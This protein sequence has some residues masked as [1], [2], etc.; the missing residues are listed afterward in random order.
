MGRRGFPICIK[1]YIDAGRVSPAF[2]CDPAKLND[3]LQIDSMHFYQ[4][5]GKVAALAAFTGNKNSMI[6]LTTSIEFEEKSRVIITVEIKDTSDGLNEELA[7][8]FN[9]YMNKEIRDFTIDGYPDDELRLI[10]YLSNEGNA[11]VSMRSEYAR[12]NYYK[13]FMSRGTTVT[14]EIN[15]HTAGAA[16]CCVVHTEEH[17]PQ[18]REHFRSIGIKMNYVPLYKAA[19]SMRVIGENDFVVVEFGEEP[20]PSLMLC[21]DLYNTYSNICIIAAMVNTHGNNEML[22]ES[23]LEHVK[24][25]IP[26]PYNVDAIIQALRLV[27]NNQLIMQKILS[28]FI[29]D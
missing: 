23:L 19:H 7:M 3:Y 15:T 2:H 10:K 18:L 17:D 14:D 25:I 11:Y 1:K 5:V 4:L 21:R 16:S 9:Q 22:I 6:Y 24:C 26:K 28:G 27:K 13:I 29:P 20:Q 8:A 12:G